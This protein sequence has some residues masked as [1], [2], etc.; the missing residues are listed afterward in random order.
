MPI[1]SFLILFWSFPLLEMK[2]SPVVGTYNKEDT[3]QHL[4]F[5]FMCQEETAYPSI[6]ILSLLF[7]K[8]LFFLKL[9][10][11]LPRIKTT[12][13]ASLAASIA[14]VLRSCP[15]DIESGSAWNFWELSWQLEFR[16]DSWYSSSDLGH[17]VDTTQRQKKQESLI[18]MMLSYLP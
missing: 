13:P 7:K 10:T 4:R 9:G 2:I 18:I 17:E 14:N 12:F 5:H 15:K 3:L 1:L 11:R 8:T 16:W 6:F